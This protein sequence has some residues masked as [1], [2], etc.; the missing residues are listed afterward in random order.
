MVFTTS[1]IDKVLAYKTWD[2]KRKTDELLRMDSVMY[3]NLGSDSTKSEKSEVRVSSRKIYL[4]IKTIDESTGI[5]FLQAM[6][7]NKHK[8]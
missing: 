7:S 2:T 4:G 8:T 5:L 3:S 6:D 1:D